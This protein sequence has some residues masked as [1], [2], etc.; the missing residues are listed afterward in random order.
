MVLSQHTFTSQRLLR[1]FSPQPGAGGWV[2][3]P[4]GGGRRAVR[5]NVDTGQSLE[6]TSLRTQLHHQ[7]AGPSSPSQVASAA[8]DPWALNTTQLPRGAPSRPR[9]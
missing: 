7:K 4:A 5:V 6:S 2:Q 8:G 1:V 3:E 9:P